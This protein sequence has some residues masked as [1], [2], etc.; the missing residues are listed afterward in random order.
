MIKH[1][2]EFNDQRREFMAYSKQLRDIRNR[3]WAE[4][5]AKRAAWYEEE[6]KK[7]EEEEAK[8][9]RWEE[10]KLIEQLISWVG[11]YLPKKEEVKEEAKAIRRRA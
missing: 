3:E 2:D 7:R 1:R 8:R 5:K 4:E 10:E 11:R 6:R 9:D